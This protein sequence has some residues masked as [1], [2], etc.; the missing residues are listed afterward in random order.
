MPNY[1]VFVQRKRTILEHRVVYVTSSSAS[2]ANGDACIAAAS[3]SDEWETDN[4]S[5]TDIEVLHTQELTV[6]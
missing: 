4:V 3:S 2:W 5:S 1:R 6:P